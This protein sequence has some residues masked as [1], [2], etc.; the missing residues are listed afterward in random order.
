[1]RRMSDYGILVLFCGK[2]GSGKSTK[3][4]EIT[5]EMN[6][7]LISEDEWLSQLYPEEITS[8]EDYVKYSSR[9]KPVIKSHVQSLL[10]TGISVVM[11][12]PGNT[13]N[14]RSWFR[15]IFQEKSYPHKLVYLEADDE[16]CL[17]RLALRQRLHPERANFD[18]PEVFNLVT[19]YFETPSPN[20]G[21]SIEIIRQSN[22]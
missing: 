17:N 22:T 2:M 10:E 14:Q 9:L 5:K 21:F 15:E 6:A 20:E 3:A 8:F 19:A 7:I 13:K 12:F 1:M 4:I 16:V 18:N 11:D